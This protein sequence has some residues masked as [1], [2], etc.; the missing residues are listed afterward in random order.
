M[1]DRIQGG[2]R[3]V[4][5]ARSLAVSSILTSNSGPSP[6]TYVV[7]QRANAV[8]GGARRAGTGR[9]QLWSSTRPSQGQQLPEELVDAEPAKKTRRSSKTP[10]V[11]PNPP[12]L[13]PIAAFSRLSLSLDSRRASSTPSIPLDAQA[14]PRSMSGTPSLT[15]TSTVTSSASLSQ[16]SSS[17]LT[18]TVRRPT[19]LIQVDKRGN[20]GCILDEPDPPRLVI[21][22]PSVSVQGQE[23][24]G[25]GQLLVIDS[26]F[27]VPL[28][29]QP[30]T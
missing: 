18:K 13:A 17:S 1:D 22:L 23:S 27:H 24:A 8:I 16:S 9:V 15:R 21:F 12:M 7:S 2:G 25:S 6:T 10:L 20:V 30:P 4:S 26:T 11:S 28:H 29:Q 14:V 5:S 3:L 19:N